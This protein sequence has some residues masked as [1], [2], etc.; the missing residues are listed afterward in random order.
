MLI[1]QIFGQTTRDQ[2]IRSSGLEPGHALILSKGLG[3]EATAIIAREK[4]DALL[5][6]GYD[7]DTL[8][9]CT[10]FLHTPGISVVEDAQ[11]ATSAGCVTAMHDPTEGGVATGLFELATASHVG[12]LSLIHISEPTRPY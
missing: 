4:R 3:I 8:T 1:G 11:I 2:L 7:A 5:A 10:E 6:R 12:L 9:A